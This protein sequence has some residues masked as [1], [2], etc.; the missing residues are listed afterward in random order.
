MVTCLHCCCNK[1]LHQLEMFHLLPLG[2]SPQPISEQTEMRTPGVCQ[3]QQTLVCERLEGTSAPA[4]SV[5][6]SSA[7][8]LPH[9]FDFLGL[10]PLGER[11][12]GKTP[13]VCVLCV[14]KVEWWS[15]KCCNGR[16]PSRFWVSWAASSVLIS[17]A[18]EHTPTYTSKCDLYPQVC[19][20]FGLSGQCGWGVC[21]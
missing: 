5:P 7:P 13:G 3:T 12:G 2:S 16:K 11:G 8:S 9:C 4:I 14:W 19:V 17:G 18:P 15:V 6:S 1:N 21:G 20:V 10:P